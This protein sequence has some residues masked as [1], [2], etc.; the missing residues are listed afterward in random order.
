MDVGHPGDGSRCYGDAYAI[1]LHQ[2]LTGV[3]VVSD[4]FEISVDLF[5]SMLETLD[6][7]D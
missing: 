5:E 6:V 4:V 7:V 3:I 2:T 1:D